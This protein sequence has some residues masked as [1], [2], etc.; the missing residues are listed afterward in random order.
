MLGECVCVFTT[1][2][3]HYRRKSDPVYIAILKIHAISH[4]LPILIRVI[5][6]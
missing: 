1:L 2:L 3:S 4:Q 5:I 6:Y